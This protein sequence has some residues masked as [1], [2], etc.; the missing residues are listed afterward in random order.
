RTP[1]DGIKVLDLSRVLAGPWC[2][3]TLADLGAEVWKVESPKGGD[4]TRKW[5]PPS[6]GGIS[7]YYLSVNRNKRALAIDMASPRGAELVRGLVAKADVVVENFMPRSLK[8]LGL[9]YESLRAINPRVIHCAISGY[10]RD[11]PLAERPGYDFVMQAECGLM[12]ITGTREGEPL[13]FGVAI[14]DLVSG[15]NATQA[16]LAA[17]YQRTLTGEGQSIDVALHR[18]GLQLLANIASGYLNTGEEPA[19]FGNAHASIVPYQSFATADG[20]LALAV[21][22]DEQFRRLCREVLER[23]DLAEAPAYATNRQRAEN[24]PALVA[25]LA[26]LFARQ[27]TVHWLARLAAAGVPAGKV[28]KVSEAFL[29][30]PELSAGMLAELPHPELG[31]VKV[32]RSPLRFS[33]SRLAEPSHPPLLGEHTAEVLGRV[34]AVAPAEIAAL[35]AAGVLFDSGLARPEGGGA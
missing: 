6:V 12:A 24:R 7:T 31:R 23:P 34:L 13:R 32:V 35:H 27:P 9:D 2:A 4:E 25:E 29:E 19:R 30:E 15:M 11:G 5:A 10:G 18:S 16:I 28:R 17:L 3:M 14:T 21:G 1:L 20:L 22:T 8:K 33:G 26:G